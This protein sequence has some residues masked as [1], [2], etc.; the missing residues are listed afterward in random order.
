MEKKKV[1]GISFGR[2]LGNTDIMIKQALIE[3]EKQGHEIKFIRADDLNIHICTGCISC[4]VNMLQ[5]KGKGDCIH[6]DE[7]HILDEAL[8][9]S[10]AVI[11]GSPTYI[12][13]P[14]GNFKVVCDRIGPSHDPT[15]RKPVYEE[16]IAAGKPEEKLP[17]KRTWKNRVGA[18]ITVGGAVTEN[19]LSLAMPSM[20]EFTM[21]LNI[22]VVDHYQFHGAMK[23]EHVLGNKEVMERMTKLGANISD[24]L[25]SDEGPENYKWRGDKEGVCPTCHCDLL[26]IIHD[27]NKVECPVCGIEGKLTLDNNK[28]KV[29]FS[30]K[31]IKRS[32]LFWAGKVEHSDEIKYEAVGPGQ[33]PDLKELKKKYVGIGE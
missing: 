13:A 21:P 33:I 8:M 16:G 12:L 22:Q 24:A 9:E 18:L 10:D 31:E 2:K 32:R 26:T 23:Y 11:V 19:W 6:K 28:I 30:E 1:L 17:D 27:E 25:S 29:D 7:F 15:F 5:G 4:V 3:C 20:Y 14:T